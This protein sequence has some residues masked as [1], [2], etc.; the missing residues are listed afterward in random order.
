MRAWIALAMILLGL[1]GCAP[2]EIEVGVTDA[3]LLVN[4]GTC[5]DETYCQRTACQS[6]F[7]ECV[8]KP[9]GQCPDSFSP[10]CDC[11]GV[12]YLNLCHAQQAGQSV[13]FPFEC[14][15]TAHCDQPCPFQATCSQVNTQSG[16]RCDQGQS[17]CWNVPASCPLVTQRFISCNTS[18]C[19]DLCQA[20]HSGEVFTQNATSTC[21]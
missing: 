14:P 21:Q 18:A 19:L 3:G 12:T 5:T 11:F 6:D 2:L 20:I 4:C 13:A 1:A 7:G 16:A 9:V 17:R 15:P 10:V 8:P